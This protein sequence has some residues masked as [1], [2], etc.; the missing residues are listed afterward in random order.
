MRP[1]LDLRKCPAQKEICKPL[2]ECPAG[3]IGY[4][5]DEEAPLGGRIV[6]D[7]DRCQ[8]CGDCVARCCGNAIVMETV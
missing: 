4:V 7:Y 2:Q 8:G 6:F 3:A 1:V 5:A